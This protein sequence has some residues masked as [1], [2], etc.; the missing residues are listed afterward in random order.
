MTQQKSMRSTSA[1]SNCHWTPPVVVAAP[2][3]WLLL[4]LSALEDDDDD[5]EEDT[6]TGI[7]PKHCMSMHSVWGRVNGWPRTNQLSVLTI[8]GVVDLS[9]E[10]VPTSIELA[11]TAKIN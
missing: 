10:N 3:V 6:T 4:L 8:A 1:G 7:M 9:N 11:N 5:D 2:A